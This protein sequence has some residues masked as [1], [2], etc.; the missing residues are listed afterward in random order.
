MP[1]EAARFEIKYDIFA[2]PDDLSKEERTLLVQA[3][4][5]MQN[6]HSPYSDFMVGAA[7]ELK[8]GSIVLGSNQENASYGLTIC[9]ERS[10]L[11]TVG[12]MGRHKDVKAIAVVGTGRKFNTTQPVAPCGACRQFLK[13]FEDLSGSPL[14]IFTA[15]VEGPIY[16]FEGIDKL[17][18]F[19]FGPNDLKLA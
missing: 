17:L 18:P 2:S 3:R 11:V 4:Q 6:A 9:A 12:S 5:A 13:E 16:R 8:D 7:V 14:T 10:A 1:K 19:G 15:G